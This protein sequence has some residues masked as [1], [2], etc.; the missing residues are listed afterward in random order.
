MSQLIVWLPW[1]LE[2]N[3]I[4][5]AR[6]HW[7]LEVIRIRIVWP[8]WILEVIRIRIVQPHW[9]LEVTRIH[10][11]RPHRILDVTGIRIVQPHWILEVTRILKTILLHLIQRSFPFFYCVNHLRQRQLEFS[12]FTQIT[13]DYNSVEYTL[14]LLHFLSE[15]IYIYKYILRGTAYSTFMSLN[16]IHWISFTKLGIVIIINLLGTF[17]SPQC[18]AASSVL[19]DRIIRIHAGHFQNGVL[20]PYGMLW[21]HNY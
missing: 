13:I 7:I 9:I 5:R 15:A 1:M 16:Y 4:L 6:P 10:I 19:I 21:K 18:L 11:V 3:R 17:I 8:Q 20:A 12:A 14:L 2:T